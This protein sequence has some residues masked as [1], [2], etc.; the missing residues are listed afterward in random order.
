MSN[1]QWALI[2]II[3]IGVLCLAALGWLASRNNESW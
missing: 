1:E 3:G 2:G